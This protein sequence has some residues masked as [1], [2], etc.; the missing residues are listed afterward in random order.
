MAD[1]PSVYACFHPPAGILP[2]DGWDGEPVQ[3]ECHHSVL[4]IN[5]SFFVYL[6]PLAQNSN[7]V[8]LYNRL[9]KSED[10]PTFYDSG[11]GTYVNDSKPWKS[12]FSLH[13]WKRGFDPALDE[14]VAR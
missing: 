5:S 6:L 10:Q 2:S 4:I 14:A 3:R 12:W 9:M 13:A 7:V 11:I 1:G 8:E